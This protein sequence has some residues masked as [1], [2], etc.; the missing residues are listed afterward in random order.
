MHVIIH[1]IVMVFKLSERFRRGR[2]ESNVPGWDK[3]K[4]ISSKEVIIYAYYPRK[5]ILFF[6][7][8]CKRTLLKLNS[9][10]HIRRMREIKSLN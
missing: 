10:V 4:D 7:C 3:A 5:L 8:V 6:V 2:S 1:S 9:E